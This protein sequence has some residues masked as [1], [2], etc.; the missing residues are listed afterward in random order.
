MPQGYERD[1]LGELVRGGGQNANSK[2]KG[3]VGEHKACPSGPDP[4][5]LPPSIHTEPDGSCEVETYA[6]L[7]PL[8]YVREEIERTY[9]ELLELAGA[10]KPRH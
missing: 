5:V 10:A 7:G 9:V 6:T 8:V 3:K 1:H 2:R 4:D